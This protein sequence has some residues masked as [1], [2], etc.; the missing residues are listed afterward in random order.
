MGLKAIRRSSIREDI[1]YFLIIALTFTQLLIPAPPRSEAGEARTNVVAF[2]FSQLAPEAPEGL[3]NTIRDAIAAQMIDTGKYTVRTAYENDPVLQRA[4]KEQL[5]T[6]EEVEL[7]IREPTVE[8][9]V[10]LGKLMNVDA[11]MLG[12]LDEFKFEEADGGTVTITVSVQLISVET[13]QPL[14]NGD[15]K[16]TVT[17]TAK[18]PPVEIAKEALI[19]QAVLDLARVVVDRFLG[20]PPAPP[21]PPK[22]PTAVGAVLPIILLVGAIA[23]LAGG[24]GGRGGV[25]P[26]TNA[27]SDVAVYPEANGVRIVWMPPVAKEPIEY[28]IYRQVVGVAIS[29]SKAVGGW[30]LLTK[31]PATQTQ[32]LDT[33][34]SPPQLYRYG[35]SAFF[36]DGRE[37]PIT[38]PQPDGSGMPPAVAAGIPTAPR[39]FTAT[40]GD[41]WVRLSWV[42]SPEDFVIGYRLYRFEMPKEI[43]PQDKPIADENTLRATVTEFVDDNNGKGLINGKAYFYR[44]TAVGP[45][46][47]ESMPTPVQ[48]ATP[49]DYPPQ[50]PRN[51]T[52]R[53]LDKAIELRWEPSP[54]PDVV[55]YEILRGEESVEGRS[56]HSRVLRTTPM[57]PNIRFPQLREMLSRV[58][59]PQL[60][61]IAKV[62]GRL[63]TQYVDRNVINAR[64]IYSYAIRAYD[65]KGNVSDLSNIATAIANAK[66]ITPPAPA[67]AKVTDKSVVLDLQ[68]VIESAKRDPDGDIVGVRIF[69]G[70]APGQTQTILT[71]LNKLLGLQDPLPFEA[72]QNGRFFTDDGRDLPTKSLSANTQYFYAVQLVDRLGLGSDIS[73]EVSAIPHK[74]P[75]V[76]EL[77][78]PVVDPAMSANGRSMALIMAKVLDKDGQPVGGVDVKFTVEPQN[79]GGFVEYSPELAAQITPLVSLGTLP[80]RQPLGTPQ[81]QAGG[82]QP[83]SEIIAQTDTQGIARVIYVAPKLTQDETARIIATVVEDPTLSKS[84]LMTLVAPKPTSITMTAVPQVLTADGVTLSEIKVVVKDA[85]A[86]VMGGQVV[87]FTVTAGPAGGGANDANGWFVQNGTKVPQLS[88]TTDQTTGEATAIYQAGTKIGKVVITAKCGGAEANTTVELTPGLP[89]KVVVQATPTELVADGRSTSQ[90]TATVYDAKGNPVKGT[91]I[92]FSASVG[93]VTPESATTDENGNATAVYTAGTKIGVAV[94]TARAKI[95]GAEGKAEITLKPGTAAVIQATAYITDQAGN[96]VPMPSSGIFV[97]N[98]GMTPNQA[99]IDIL[100]TD[101]T[102]NPVKNTVVTLQAVGGTVTQSVRTDDNGHAEAI[103]TAGN[104]SGQ[105]QV[106]ITSAGV[107]QSLTIPLRPGPPHFLTVNIAQAQLPADGASTTTISAL[108]TD[109]N[110]NKVEDGNEVRFTIQG[111]NLG[112]LFGDGRTQTVAVTQGGIANVTLRSGNQ[113]GQI[114]ILVQA[115]HQGQEK[116]RQ[117]VTINFHEVVVASIELQVAQSTI[118]VS[119]TNSP[120]P[121]ERH[122]LRTDISNKVVA[123]ATVRGIDGKPLLNRPDVQVMFTVSDS[124]VL[125]IDAD[126]QQRYAMG[127]LTKNIDATTGQAK[128]ILVASKTAGPIVL[129]AVSERIVQSINLTQVPGVPARLEIS[130]FPQTIPADGVS[131]AQITVQAWDANDNAVADGTAIQFSTSAGTLNPPT[132]WTVGGK[133]TTTLTSQLSKTP[134]QAVVEARVQGIPQPAKVVVVFGVT[135]ATLVSMRAEPSTIVGDGISE[136]KI[137][138]TFTDDK[139]NPIADGTTVYFD[140]TFGRIV[141]V[142][143]TKNGT[144]VAVLRSAIVTQVKI[145]QVTAVLINPD[146]SRV[147]GTVN[148]TFTPAREVLI[149]T[150]NP[151]T[152]VADGVSTSTITARL[153][154]LD[155]KPV[156]GVAVR[157]STSLGSIKAVTDVTDANGEATATLTAGVKAG[158]AIVTVRAATAEASIDVPILAGAAQFIRLTTYVPQPPLYADGFTQVKVIAEV[159]DANGNW[160]VPGTTVTFTQ[161]DAGGNQAVQT[162]LTDDKGQASVFFTSTV[163]GK[164]VVTATSGTAT[165]QISITYLP[166]VMLSMDISPAIVTADGASTA[167]VTV[168]AKNAQGNPMPNVTIRFQASHG[169]IT[170]QAVTDAQ[171]RA[172]ATYTS[173]R[174]NEPT[175][176]VTIIAIARFLDGTEQ[177]ITGVLTLQGIGAGLSLAANP[178]SL[179]A[180][181]KSEAMIRVL[182]LDVQN[183]PVRGLT[184]KFTTTAGVLSEDTAQTGADGTATVKLR[185]PTAPT[186]AIVTATI[187]PTATIGGISIASTTVTFNPVTV[188]VEVDSNVLVADGKSTTTV[189][190]RMLDSQ[191][192]PVA[193]GVVVNFGVDEGSIVP[194]AATTVNGVAVATYTAGR[195]AGVATVVANVVALNLSGSAS[196]VL[197]SMEARRV[198][199]VSSSSRLMADGNDVVDIEARVYDEAGNLVSDGAVVCIRADRGTFGAVGVELRQVHVSTVNGVGRV[200]LRS[201]EEGVISVEGF[202]DNDRDFAVDAGTIAGQVKVEAI[203]VGA[204][205]SVSVNRESMPADGLSRAKVRVSLRDAQ[206]KPV[207]GVRVKVTSDLGRVEPSEGVSDGAGRC[208]FEL[209]SSTVGGV[210][211]VVASALWQGVERVGS[212]SVTMNPVSIRLSLSQ[213]EVRADGQS[214]VVVSAL[215]SDS[216]GLPVADGVVVN[217][218]VDEGSIVP[219]AATTVNGVAVATYTAGRRAGV[220]TVVANV[221]ALNLSGSASIVLRSMEARRV[222]LVSSSSRL[223]ADGNDVVDIEARV[224]DEAGNLVSDGAVVCIRADR[225]TFGAVGVELRQVHV[226][227]VNGVGRVSL[228]SEEEGVISVEGFV[229]NDRDFAVDAGTIAGQVKVEAIGVGA[230]ISVSVNRE[231]MP[232]DGL[233]RA[234]VRVSLRDAQGKPV[235]GVRVKVTSDLGRVEPSEGVSDGAGRCEFELVSSTVGGV[236]NVVASALWQGVERVGSASVTMNPV[237]IRLSLS[238]G[239]VRADGQSK[240]VVSALVSDSAGLPVADGVVIRFATDNGQVMPEEARTVGGVVSA[241][242]VAGKRAGVATVVASAVTLNLS[243]SVNIRLLPGAPKRVVASASSYNLPADGTSMV[244]LTANAYDEAGN[245]VL[246]GTLICFATDGGTFGPLGT[247]VKQVHVPTLNGVSTVQLR[248]TTPGTITVSAFIDVDRDGQP[249]PTTEGAKVVIQA[250]PVPAVIALNVT[251]T[252]LPADG[253]SKTQISATVRDTQGRPIG[254]ID[255]AFTTTLGRLSTSSARTDQNGLTPQVELVAPTA[256]G[257]ATVT[258]SVVVNGVL[259]SA[260]STVT[261]NQV[262]IVVTSDKAQLN[263]DGTST[264]TITARL[265]DSVTGAPVA[266]GIFVD[267]RTDNGQVNPTRVATANGIATCTFTAGVRAGSANIFADVMALGL[268]ASTSIF[269]RAKEP[270]LVVADANPVSIP[271]DGNSASQITATVLD[272]DG[273]IVPDGVIVTFA[274]DRGTFGPRLSNI[275][276]TQATTLNGQ[277]TV[278]LRS[279]LSPGLANVTAFIDKNNNKKLDAGEPSSTAVV[280]MTAVAPGLT[281]T[282]DR[283]SMP[284]DGVSVATLQVTLRDALNRP[285]NASGVSFST[286]AGKLINRDDTDAA[287][288]I[289]RIQLQADTVPATATVVAT[290]KLD[291]AEARQQLNI[292]MNPLTVSLIADKER[293]KANGTDSTTL[294]ARV[295]DVANNPVSGVTAEFSVD[296]GTVNPQQS[297]VKNGEATTTLT[298]SK[299]S[300]VATI[301]VRVLRYVATV[302]VQYVPVDIAQVLVSAAP[303]SI[304]V[305]G[306]QSLITATVL[307]SGNRPVEGASVTFTTDKGYIVV[308]RS[309]TDVNGQ[310]V[311]VLFSDTTVGEATVTAR[312]LYEG[313]EKVGQTKVQFMP[314][315][316]ARITLE[317]RNSKGEIVDPN[318]KPVEAN[319]IDYYEVIAI[320]TDQYGNP[321]RDGTVVTWKIDPNFR[322]TAQGGVSTTQNGRAR[323]EI[324]SS[325]FSVGQVAA[326]VDPVFATTQ[327]VFVPGP[328]VTVVANALPPVIE[329]GV[330]EALITARA[331]DALK[332]QINIELGG[333][334]GANVPLVIKG[335]RSVDFVFTTTAGL[336]DDLESGPNHEIGTTVT[337]KGDTI[338]D[339]GGIATVK[340]KAG[341]TANTV[342]TVTVKAGTATGTA[343]VAFVASE[344]AQLVARAQPQQLPGNM[345]ATSTI[346]VEVRDAKGNPVRDE[347]PVQFVIESG[348]VNDGVFL[349]SNGTRQ[350]ALTTNGVATITYR[351]GLNILDGAKNVPIKISSGSAE[352]TL[353]LTLQSAKPHSATLTAA[354]PAIPANGLAQST[355]TATLRDANGNPVPIGTVVIFRTD[356]G[357]FVNATS[358]DGKEAR[359]ATDAN[360]VAVAVL[361]S[362]TRAGIANVSV[363]QAEINGTSV[364][365]ANPGKT[366]VQMFGVP[367]L[368]TLSSDRTSLP[369]DGTSYATLTLTLRDARGNP[370]VTDPTRNDDNIRFT[371]T[372]GT[373]KK[374]DGTDLPIYGIDTDQS[375]TAVVRLVAPTAPGVATVTATVVRDGVATTAQQ[376]IDFNPL[377]VRVV[378]NPQVIKADGASTSLISAFLRD[379]VTGEPVAQGT[380]VTFTTTLGNIKTQDESAEL[381]GIQVSVKGY[382]GQVTAELQSGNVP[383]VAT[384]N[385]SVGPSLGSTNVT[386]IGLPQSI[387]LTPTPG[388]IRAGGIETSTITAQV[389]DAANNPVSDGTVVT[390]KSTLGTLSPDEDPTKDG[391]QRRTVEGRTFVLLRSGNEVGTAVVSAETENG[392]T[393]S[394][395]VLITSGAPASIDIVAEPNRIVADGV[396]ASRIIA[397]VKDAMNNPVA[398]AT[399]TFS[400]TMGT[401]APQTSLTNSQ[402]I[403]TAT[404]TSTSVGTA[405]VTATCGL[406]SNRVTVTVIKGIP[407]TVAVS[408]DVDEVFVQD[409]GK[410][411][412]EATLTVTVR[413]ANN[414]PVSGV[415][416]FL[417]TTLGSVTSSVTTDAQGKATAKFVSGLQSGNATITVQAGN[418]VANLTIKVRPGPPEFVMLNATP[419]VILADGVST[420]SLQ[421]TVL[422]KNRNAVEDGTQVTFTATAGTVVGSPATTVN[423]QASATLRS[424]TTETN[425]TVTAT[426]N[427]KSDST[428]VRFS[429]VEPATIQLTA[430]PSSLSVKDI[431]GRPTKSTVTV[432][433]LDAQ[434][435][436]VVNGTPVV[437]ST[438][439]GIFTQSGSDIY[440]ATTS[441]GQVVATL[442]VSNETESGIALVRAESGKATA[443]LSIPV[444]PGPPEQITLT[445]MPSSIPADGVSACTL[446]AKVMDKYGNPIPNQPVTFTATKGSINPT[447][448]TTNVFGTATATLTSIPSSTSIAVQ[449]TAQSANKTATFVVTFTPALP[450]AIT[451]TAN[452]PSIPADGTASTITAVVRDA[453]GNPVPDGTEVVFVTDFGEFTVGSMEQRVTTTNGQAVVML[454]SR[455]GLAGTAHVSATSGNIIQTVAVDITAGAPASIELTATPQKVPAD[456][457]S[458]AMV[459]AEV[460]DAGGNPVPFVTVTF[461][462]TPTLGTFT[463]AQVPTN[464]EGVAITQIRS[465]KVGVAN[466]TA[467]AGAVSSATVQVEFVTPTATIQLTAKPTTI[468]ADGGQAL[469]TATVMDGFGKP[470]P[471]GTTVRFSMPSLQHGRLQPDT[472]ANPIAESVRTANG[473][474]SITLV[475]SKQVPPPGTCPVT[476]E[477][478]TQTGIVRA[479]VQVI[480]AKEPNRITLTANPSSIVANGTS[481]SQIRA[482]VVDENN[483][484]VADG[485]PIKWQTTAGRIDAQS[486]TVNGEAWATLTSSPVPQAQPVKVTAFYDANDNN[487]LDAGEASGTVEVIFSAG[488]AA[489]LTLTATPQT[490]SA[491]GV[492]VV[493]LK[494]TV[495]D[496]LG[497]PVADG[498]AV[499]FNTNLGTFVGAPAPGTTYPTSTVNGEA[500]ASLISN[501]TGL[502]TV[503]VQVGLLARQI[504]VSFKPGQPASI[505][506]SI[507]PDVVFPEDKREALIT[508]TVLDRLGNPVEDGTRVKFTVTAP[509]GT[510]YTANLKKLDERWDNIVNT[511]SGLAQI[512]LVRNSKNDV[513]VYTVRANVLSNGGV[514]ASALS[515]V[516]FAGE[517][518]LLTITANPTTI[519][520]DGRSTSTITVTARDI[521]N[522]PVADGTV[523]N[524]ITTQGSITATGRTVDGQT[525]AILTSSMQPTPAGGAAVVTAWYDADG[526]RMPS[527]GFEPIAKVSVVFTTGAPARVLLSADPTKLVADGVSTSKLVANVRDALDRPIADG[528]PVTFTTTLGTFPN[529]QQTFVATT[530]DGQA[531]TILTSPRTPGRTEVVATV[532]GIQ[533]ERVAILF[534]PGEPASIRLSASLQRLKAG[535]NMTTLLTA[536]VRD[537]NGNA[538]ADG[539][540]VTFEV[541][542]TSRFIP[543]MVSQTTATTVNGIAIATLRGDSTNLNPRR[544]VV[545]ASATTTTGKVSATTE[546]VFV[547]LPFSIIVSAMPVTLTAD[548]NAT[549]QIR[550]TLYDA[551]GNTVYDGTPVEWTLTPTPS[552][553]NPT[554]VTAQSSTQGGVVTATL[555]AP[556]R[557]GSAAIT[558]KALERDSRAPDPL[559][560]LVTIQ[561]LENAVGR[562]EVTAEPPEIDVLGVN[563]TESTT[564]TARVYDVA[565]NPV[566]DGT[567]VNFSTTRGTIERAKPTQG[568][569][570][571]AT[572]T[573]DPTADNNVIV[574]AQVGTVVGQTTVKFR[575]GPAKQ[576]MVSASPNRLIANGRSQSAIVAR[577]EDVNGNPVADA[578]PLWFFATQDNLQPG[579]F[580]GGTY[581]TTQNRAQVRVFTQGG[582]A[583]A[584]LRSSTTAGTVTITAMAFKITDNTTD[585]NSLPSPQATGSTQV[586]YEGSVPASVQVTVEPSQIYVS[587]VGLEPSWATITARVLDK[588]GVPVEGGSATF[589][590]AA[591]QGT[592]T[593]EYGN[594]N[595]G[596]P[597]TETVPIGVG[598]NAGIAKARLTSGRYAGTVT[599]TVTATKAGV[600][601]SGIGSITY[602]PGP[603]NTVVCFASPT[604]IPADGTSVT[605]IWAIVRDTYGNPIPSI[606]VTFTSDKGTITAPESVTN[607]NGIATTILRSVASDKTV[608]ANVTCRAGEKSGTTQV[609]F[610]SVLADTVTLSAVPTS[611]PADDGQSAMTITATVTARGQ[612]VPDG[613][614]VT[615]SVSAGTIDSAQT[616][617]EDPA[618]SGW[619]RKTVQGSAILRLKSGRVAGP[620]FITAVSGV[621]AANLQV[622]FSPGAPDEA[623]CTISPNPSTI[624]ADGTTPS[625][626]TVTVLDKFQNP[627]PGIVVNFT[628]VGGNVNPA[629]SK[630]NAQGIA[631]TQFTSTTQGQATVTASFGG[632]VKSVN[633]TVEAA[634]VASITLSFSVPNLYVTG[635]TVNGQQV[636]TTPALPTEG[637]VTATVRDVNGNPVGAGIVVAFSTTLGTI[638]ASATTTA[639]GSAQVKL[640]SGIVAG[641]ARVTAT[642]GTVRGTIDVP[643]LPGDP[644]SIMVS[645]VPT[646]I[647][648]DGKSTAEITATVRDANNNPVKDGTTIE[649]FSRDT[650][651]GYPPAAGDPPGNP[652]G[653]ITAKADTMN[654]IAKATLVSKSSTVPLIAYVSARARVGAQYV[655]SDSIP[656]NA[657]L[658][659]LEVTFEPVAAATLTLSAQPSKIYVSGVG[660]IPTTSIITAQVLDAAGNPVPDGTVVHWMTDRGALQDPDSGLPTNTTTTVGGVAKIQLASGPIA[661]LATVTA[662]IRDPNNNPIV[663]QS[664]QVQFLPGLPAPYPHSTISANPVTISGNGLSTSTIAVTLRD[665]NDNPVVDGT[666]V[667]FVTNHGSIQ[668][669]KG[670]EQ[671]T[672]GGVSM[673]V[674]TSEVV[675]TDTDAYVKANAPAG[676]PFFIGTDIDGSQLGGQHCIVT[677]V[678]SI[679]TTISASIDKSRLT[680]DGV[681]TATI[682]VRVADQFGLPVP[683]G[684]VIDFTTNLGSVTTP[685]VTKNGIATAVYTAGTTPG[686]A[687]INI[688]V[689]DYPHIN[690]GLNVYLPG[691]VTQILIGYNPAVIYEP[692][693]WAD[694]VDRQQIVAVCVDRFG[695]PVNEVEIIWTTTAGSI[696]PAVDK[697]GPRTVSGFRGG[698]QTVQGASIATLVSQRSVAGLTA[699]VTAIVPNGETGVVMASTYVGFTGVPTQ[700]DWEWLNTRTGLYNE[701][702]AIYTPPGTQIHIRVRVRDQNGVNVPDG[703]TV[704]FSLVNQQGGDGGSLSNATQTTSNG[705]THPWLHYGEGWGTAATISGGTPGRYWRTQVQATVSTPFGS[706]TFTAPGWFGHD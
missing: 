510:D 451:L 649:F 284:A 85:F 291:G 544:E 114:Q 47:Y 617:D 476:A 19:K 58:R 335:K 168:V 228:R 445:A 634:P 13:G 103:F 134:I 618:T 366:T 117:I 92:A 402:G 555:K 666:K 569:V 369:A 262:T 381:A 525:T 606:K 529:G 636:G 539:T 676:S 409:V 535:T 359:D 424:S 301:Q 682:T 589:S 672:V 72:L 437:L 373:L 579:T 269:L 118:A 594:D 316:A 102:G 692:S 190:A 155:G 253:V 376:T 612:P 643:I 677:M 106:T 420:A 456:N 522:M 237:S 691:G 279:L 438:S 452:P 336:L 211:N 83:K 210:A 37:S 562:I 217:F 659:P 39:G 542:G 644:A 566:P 254:G 196:I 256:S 698:A 503:T 59:A 584:V 607:A 500:S 405:Y 418:V 48:P 215:V 271:A 265:M 175:T 66:P 490:Q 556:N 287:K 513:G 327:L 276:V 460:R 161:T 455:S 71:S 570:A 453:N 564:I 591:N 324:L 489:S 465:N 626:I 426:A 355:I 3:A 331:F 475:G 332:N 588:N 679:P 430:Q 264:A 205:I 433:V 379:A 472:D 84:L 572:L 306:A 375:G 60:R 46:R 123:T 43:T 563:G 258:A 266:D 323:N 132:A 65:E 224:Y 18:K 623:Q 633:V 79:R 81:R 86:E 360:G 434:G 457:Q 416:V 656:G 311:A 231:S 350:T 194:Q 411:P 343:S 285:I 334:P 234:K 126:N 17:R 160:V 537:A 586:V 115:L 277:A 288:G 135:I 484:A 481:T 156:Q 362:D 577:V 41:R 302:Q 621:A 635:V 51:L 82:L 604:E 620:V 565:G 69:R 406:V 374:A 178:P 545:T 157:F 122:P 251:K 611:I 192:L 163:A 34:A 524:F 310:A 493:Q 511:V 164:A 415:P 329:A 605:T 110:N 297:T 78:E 492:S 419:N 227:T 599:I 189:R 20:K 166:A 601:E 52:A 552:T 593:D 526:D 541:A 497:N 408:S 428:T 675:A 690:T 121:A 495:K 173:P 158:V 466:I 530:S 113:V 573:S 309:R 136:A 390:F 661:G 203:G 242:Y 232:A 622:T 338:V 498:T 696:T 397:T 700:V 63:N 395:L 31:V 104:T 10:A 609:T 49:G 4:I 368:M 29:R 246:D 367:V 16:E 198:V 354:P 615:F 145:V 576:I 143:P 260:S 314:G 439:K 67:I 298:S 506:L 280:E 28:R 468:K 50:P 559:T 273:N 547:G 9:A 651:V 213:G 308:Q 377:T 502:A 496:E 89:S 313:I 99:I 417:T 357:T 504:V 330:G 548:G 486:T 305:G 494:A 290:A 512:K 516:R 300:G 295:Y 184:V 571:V 688:S 272:V 477:A 610:S 703:T 558:I 216:A 38:E 339:N 363:E 574:T 286:T 619:Q 536:D 637:T 321:V 435:R 431:A 70:F 421:A 141:S 245:S 674:L 255:V 670:Y 680:P 193:D 531:S 600:T 385:A 638:E 319:N 467:V 315:Q 657:T 88:L 400:A 33:T 515:Q 667:A 139:G 641:T 427:G 639:G 448:A 653:T 533:S 640:S 429:K 447:T 480:L 592:L 491:D 441:N 119:D 252:Q 551:L 553:I 270:A 61:P 478:T 349:P 464:N 371:T 613:T 655:Y 550:A 320:V 353:I 685:S 177:R 412:T 208:E 361:R 247:D 669:A 401:V 30:Q 585:P 654:G 470:V 109:A 473:Q 342:A 149:I 389:F 444:E 169:T 479:T 100:V 111:N 204:G 540:K 532:A 398:G 226:S 603:V 214:K 519:V 399:V 95:N 598:I 387:V 587:G 704:T 318:E 35:V 257:V 590:I 616:P 138:A 701:P 687:V 706:L 443:S 142:T 137:Y 697:T 567:I 568:G 249:D 646:V 107:S 501:R 91:E 450:A 240:V 191:G 171:G 54:D 73:P 458:V 549:S 130:A 24:K 658:D 304:L 223:M 283:L 268:S 695:N 578:T 413:D 77:P 523:I 179:P 699:T 322:Q 554:L 383:G 233:S 101:A 673:A 278:T 370:I 11:V 686:I 133:A 702:V 678:K 469:I 414:A 183:R 153:V 425:V 317:V 176:V 97:S 423:G 239:E 45:Q 645:A 146:G 557:P 165:A 42:K 96:K 112:A 436:R 462:T 181:G 206:G 307:D 407:A 22:R 174:L 463:N 358:A 105:A 474:A 689:H 172:T 250:T 388:I 597:T 378:A 333:T 517:P 76:I 219:Q 299:V 185:A 396:T 289:V 235:V 57:P 64:F 236:A 44:L 668:L 197:R 684:T 382:D 534:T 167:T 21:T 647:P 170:D 248:T 582:I 683:D 116:A 345:I 148:V 442:D 514:L 15:V 40:A 665:A 488:P 602:L 352:I 432:I 681:S 348:D 508:A 94:V 341:G 150:A 627:I 608:V 386:L 507:V 347:T 294:R 131:T 326:I 12:S 671:G 220:A 642:V 440:E 471:D 346:R 259:A 23:A 68:A 705:W 403:A 244:T 199:L 652:M 1:C 499:I 404:F 195:R 392:V 90:I 483:H 596:S 693:I 356:K 580:I 303:V 365:I 538:V 521:L 487:A 243:Q 384:V 7:A 267:F 129:T 222:V 152:L 520:A 202:V 312:A 6:P 188:V 27:P 275:T 632:I 282:A 631:T 344:A 200:S 53:G 207:V 14:P 127:A 663:S 422:D 662:T 5:I 461:S 648:A 630:T 485:T 393:A 120:E 518:A 36:E 55:A 410:T 351:S 98:V 528:T 128:V 509:D 140:T 664:T 230:G 32:Y 380:L 543:G 546:I 229:D 180:D 221:V 2:S 182:A 459:R 162:A 144:A 56:P 80:L 212:A 281:L 151:S 561:F 581:D 624:P 187:P 241:Q 125:L 75:S 364:N 238:Q 8:R 328:P 527:Y 505:A 391:A 186:T 446:V 340:L 583:T 614:V 225:G 372:N 93:S 209:V 293:L 296:N 560:G 108:V 274:T 628:A 694:G 629:Q 159:T 337:V 660:L 261:F 394:A 62:T 154:D 625:T 454:R 218:G 87:T 449:V 25:A 575:P 26:A 147:V 650:K 292:T 482:L 201:E 263:A 124:N 325:T 595:D 74:P